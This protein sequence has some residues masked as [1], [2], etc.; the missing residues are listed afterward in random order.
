MTRPTNMIDHMHYVPIL[1][2]RRGEYGALQTMSREVREHLTPI[3]EIPPVPWDHQRRQPAKTIDQHLSRVVGAVEQSWGTDRPAFV[4]LL[5]NESERMADKSHPVSYIFG[6]AR[7]QGLQIV[8]VTGLA[9][10]NDYQSACRDAVQQDGRGICLRIQ[11]EDYEEPQDLG[12]QVLA[13][14]DVL[15]V[16]PNETD[17]VLDL[18]AVNAHEEN[19]LTA[20]L[21]QLILK[22]PQIHQWRSFTLAATGFPEDLMGLPPLGVSFV[23][24]IEWILW[25]SLA[26]GSRIP[27]FPTFGD[28]GIAHIQPSEVDPRIMRPSASIRY[29]TAESWLVLKGRNLRDYGFDQFHGVSRGLVARPEYMRPE[30]SWGDWYINECANRRV[31]SGNLTTW[32]KVGTSHHLAYVTHQIASPAGPSAVPER[33]PAGRLS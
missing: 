13:L 1:K 33:Y 12:Q 9:R 15:R 30:F 10:D 23:T 4:D 19:T 26:T 20:Q 25:R 6:S 29:T 2:G 17:L 21:P 31:G 18:R 28:Y 3:L 16:A 7:N 14:L 32:R 27:R 8:P 11:R 24:R 22:V 5:W